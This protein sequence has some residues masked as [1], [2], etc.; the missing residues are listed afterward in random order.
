MNFYRCTG[1]QLTV[2]LSSILLLIATYCTAK[3]M[4]SVYKQD[5]G[6]GVIVYADDYVN[7]GKWVFDCNYSRLISRYPL[8]APFTE[9]EHAP[10]LTIGS[11]YNLN[12]NEK[13]MAKAAIRAVTEIHDWQNGLRYLYSGLD[14]N[15][16]LTVHDF[17]LLAEHEGRKWAL[18]VSQYIRSSSE[19][20]FTIVAQPYDPDTYMDYARVLEAAAKSCPAPQ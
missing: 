5:F 8:P 1:V 2:T 7:S 3:G 17:D 18:I 16:Y 19:S 13:T 12:D 6:N 11:M 10:K 9:L 20:N 14:E 15:S 4:M